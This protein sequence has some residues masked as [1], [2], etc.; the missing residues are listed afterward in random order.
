MAVMMIMKWGGVSLDEYEKVR[1]IVDWDNNLPVGGILHVAA[2][3]GSGLRIT[4]VWESP[5]SFQTF[6]ETRLTPAVQQA[7]ITSQPEVEVY[8]AHNVFT[9]G[10]VKK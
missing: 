1:K 9:P 10:F 4:D 3:D 7:G 8:P 6:V 2:H 5:E